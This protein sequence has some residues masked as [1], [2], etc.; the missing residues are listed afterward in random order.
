MSP[1]K[2]AEAVIIGMNL[3]VLGTFLTW[4]FLGPGR[5][6]RQQ[7]TEPSAGEE[8]QATKQ[9]FGAQ[10]AERNALPGE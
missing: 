4:R 5:T 6:Q 9:T 7:K 2:F 8:F 1:A 3:L 10:P